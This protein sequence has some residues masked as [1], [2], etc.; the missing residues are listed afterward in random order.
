[1]EFKLNIQ[2]AD[3]VKKTL[4]PRLYRSAM[5]ATLNDLASAVN[6]QVAKQIH[7]RYTLSSARIK[8]G[9][10]VKPARGDGMQ[11]VLTFKGNPPGLQHYKAV[12][13]LVNI[14]R[15]QTSKGIITR[16]FKRAHQMMKGVSVEVIKGSRKIV[17]GAFL[18]TTAKGGQG[19]LRRKGKAI[20]RLFGP[21]IKGMFIKMGGKTIAEKVVG[22]QF[23]TKFWRNVQRYGYKKGM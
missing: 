11:A 18:I 3:G 9:I 20:Y 13:T 4:D 15:K 10:N 22:E 17:S 16:R 2:G 7:E 21:S 12:Q 14:Q 23:T 1:M 6:T 5:R 19:I 8:E